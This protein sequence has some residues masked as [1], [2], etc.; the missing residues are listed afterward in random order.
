MTMHATTTSR[1]TLVQV[2][3]RQAIT[4]ADHRDVIGSM[5]EDHPPAP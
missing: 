1:C 5:L 3:L 2:G 4:G